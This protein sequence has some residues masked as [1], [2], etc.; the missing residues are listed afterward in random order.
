LE[1]ALPE[2]HRSGQAE[3]L[4][5]PFDHTACLAVLLDEDAAG[6]P[7]GQRLQAHGP[8]AGEEV[9]DVGALDRSD[10]RERRFSDAVPGRAGD[11]TAWCGDP[12][13][14]PRPGDDSHRPNTRRAGD[15]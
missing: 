13:P 11:D 8:R 2:Y 3:L 14:F 7:T 10:Q 6:R 15:A 5:V 12:V 4:E 1:D 9:E